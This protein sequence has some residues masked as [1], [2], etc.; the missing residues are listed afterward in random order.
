MFRASRVLNPTAAGAGAGK[1]K[2]TLA[3]KR[4]ARLVN[5][6]VM[7]VV[8]FGKGIGNRILR[9]VLKLMKMLLRF[10]SLNSEVLGVSYSI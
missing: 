9:T 6:I 2:A 10:L 7:V 3:I 8:C 1:A 5:C 4:T